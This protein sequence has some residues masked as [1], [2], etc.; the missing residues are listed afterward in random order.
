M[1]RKSSIIVLLAIILIPGEA[2]SQRDKGTA[3]AAGVVAAGAVA[4]AVSLSVED[5]KE[6]LEYHANN[7]VVSNLG[8]THYL[9]KLLDFSGK[10]RT[11]DG[12]QRLVTFSYKTYNENLTIKERKIIFMHGSPGWISPTGLR[13]ES[14]TYSVW[15]IERWDRA[16]ATIAEQ[17]ALV[18]LD[19]ARITFGLEGGQ[20]PLFKKVDEKFCETNDEAYLGIQGLKPGTVVCYKFYG[21]N[22]LSLTELEFDSRG[23]CAKNNSDYYLPF[24]RFNGD[25]YV[26]ADFDEEFKVFL[27]EET[28]GLYEIQSERSILIKEKLLKKIAEFFTDS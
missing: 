12:N 6:E 1:M 15:D 13:V 22:R 27:N 17:A 28:I 5:M 25:F 23:L 16:A 14:V 11:D 20:T 26:L 8:D 18:D 10:N 7:Y 24:R 19:A 9:L 2:Y 3:I 21:A 4:A